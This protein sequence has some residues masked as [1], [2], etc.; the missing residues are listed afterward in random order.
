MTLHPR[1]PLTKA[2][3]A[4]AGVAK[5]RVFATSA[6]LEVPPASDATKDSKAQ[7]LTSEVC[8][9]F[10]LRPVAAL[11]AALALGCG[12][13]SGVTAPAADLART[14]GAS[15][16]SVSGHIERPFPE[17]GVPIHKYSFHAHYLGDGRVEGRFVELDFI[18][19]GFKE[20]ANGRV[21]CF[22]VEA[23]GR[24]ARLGGIVEKATI[25][26]AVG[27]DAIWTV[28]DNGEG[29]NAPTDQA[30]DLRVILP[31]GLAARHCESGIPLE[32]LGTFGESVR[33]NVQVR[34]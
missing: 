10:P 8:I 18:A 12:D 30:T 25:P 20:V 19:G 16:A 6:T 5:P 28:V 15:A 24:T 3:P 2:H 11:A 26:E 33:A 14:S 7:C 1:F 29:A 32:V 4:K 31:S 9:R 17:F 34:P 23:D 22:T 21:T 27:G 13:Q